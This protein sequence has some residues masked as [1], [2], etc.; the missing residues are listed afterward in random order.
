VTNGWTGARVPLYGTHGKYATGRTRGRTLTGHSSWSPP[1]VAR[2]RC[3]TSV[4][5]RS[6][7][8]QGA[9]PQGCSTPAG[10][11][12]GH[13]R[14][15]ADR[16][17]PRPPLRVEITRVSTEGS[18]TPPGTASRGYR[19]QPLPGIGTN[20]ARWEALRKRAKRVSTWL[21]I[22]AGGM[23][24]AAT[25]SPNSTQ[26]SGCSSPRPIV[27][28]WDILDRRRFAGGRGQDNRG[29]RGGLANVDRCRGPPDLAMA[30][31]GHAVG[32]QR[33]VRTPVPG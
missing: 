31:N 21:V 32:R 27:P 30:A 3:T 14:A 6:F 20:R 25:W 17:G 26:R 15:G 18:A 11:R 24:W 22:G 8:Q 28:L 12:L 13:G 16:Q 1:A 10:S 4:A 33:P 29:Q 2:A 23:P 5:A 7:T 9:E 19:R